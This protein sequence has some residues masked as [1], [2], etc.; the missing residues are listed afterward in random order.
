[1]T[2]LDLEFIQANLYTFAQQLVDNLIP[3]LVAAIAG[4][5]VGLSVSPTTGPPAFAPTCWCAW[6][7]PSS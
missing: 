5:V 1:M 7:R 6:V 3:L 4:G 2:L